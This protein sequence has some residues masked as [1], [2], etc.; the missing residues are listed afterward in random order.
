[1][2]LRMGGH[3][4]TLSVLCIRPLHSMLSRCPAVHREKLGIVLKMSL[5]AGLL[6]VVH[7]SIGNRKEIHYVGVLI[8]F[9]VDITFL[10]APGY[11]YPRSIGVATFKE[12]GQSIIGI[13]K[14][15][16]H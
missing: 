13:Y 5:F 14:G 2:P 9:L 4:R 7:K 15:L 12:W 3:I 11:C 16:L 6:I 10:A 8:V 1:M